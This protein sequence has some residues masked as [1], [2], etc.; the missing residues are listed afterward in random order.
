[1][2]SMMFNN[3]KVEIL[4]ILFSHYTEVMANEGEK[5]FFFLLFKTSI[6]FGG[7]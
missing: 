7:K 2:V 1:M 4:D 3:S 5:E 6:R